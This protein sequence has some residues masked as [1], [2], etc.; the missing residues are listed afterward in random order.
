MAR[1]Y[2][3]DKWSRNKKAV[4]WENY[5]NYYDI[6]SNNI[7]LFANICLGVGIIPEVTRQEFYTR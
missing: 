7:V 2:E 1:M 3:F 4:L 5:M 6:D